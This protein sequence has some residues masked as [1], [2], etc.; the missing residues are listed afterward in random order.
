[1]KTIKKSQKGYLIGKGEYNQSYQN[2]KKKETESK[3]KLS[4]DKT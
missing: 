4:I 2:K 3:N 1:M